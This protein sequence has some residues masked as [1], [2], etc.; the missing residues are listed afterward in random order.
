METWSYNY[1]RY[2]M[3]KLHEE[4]RYMKRRA[5]DEEWKNMDD[6]DKKL[7]D[8]FR[9]RRELGIRDP[10]VW[11]DG[12]DDSDWECECPKHNSKKRAKK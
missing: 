10:P 4:M 11:C 3:E 5:T 1:L 6:Y 9:R 7:S 12:D 8:E 2:L